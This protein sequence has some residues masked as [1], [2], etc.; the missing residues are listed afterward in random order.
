M[1]PP[2]KG[3]DL[4]DE[5]MEEGEE[6]EESNNDD[7]ASDVEDETK[8][9]LPS[10]EELTAISIDKKGFLDGILGGEEE[11]ANTEDEISDQD[12]VNKKAAEITIEARQGGFAPIQYEASE[13]PDL[14][15]DSV[16]P[17]SEPQDTT[18]KIKSALESGRTGDKGD[19][20]AR[21]LKMSNADFI[22]LSVPGADDNINPEAPA[23]AQQA[24]RN[25]KL[26]PTGQHPEDLPPWLIGPDA[27]EAVKYHLDPTVALHYEI[28]EFARFMAPTKEEEDSRKRLLEVLGE[29]VHGLF[30]NA[31]LEIFGSYA[32]DLYLPSSDI[33]ICIM[34]TPKEGD[35]S[36]LYLLAQSIRNTKGFARRV[37]VI[38]ARVP[39][40]KI[41]SATSKI[42]CDISF[43][44]PNGPNNVPMIKSFLSTYPA[45]RPLILVIKCFLQQRALNEVYTGGIGSYT[46]LMM[47]V[48]HL[49]MSQFNFPSGQSNLGAALQK[50]FRFYGRQLNYV[51]TG[52]TIKDSSGYFRKAEKYPTNNAEA[53]RI[54][55]EDPNDE[56]NELGRNSYGWHRVRKAFEHACTQLCRWN[57]ANPRDP[58][59]PLK[60][61]L[62]TDLSFQTRV[63]EVK[64]YWATQSQQALYAKTQADVARGEKSA[65]G[66][67]RF[68]N[69]NKAKLDYT[70]QSGE[71]RSFSR[72]NDRDARAKRSRQS[73]SPWPRSSRYRNGHVGYDDKRDDRH[74]ERYSDS[75]NV[76]NMGSYPHTM[77][78]AQM[79]PQM[80]QQYQE[81]RQLQEM[82]MQQMQ[83]A[84]GASPAQQYYPNMG[85]DSMMGPPS[86]L[87]RMVQNNIPQSNGSQ[88]TWLAGRPDLRQQEGGRRGNNRNNYDR[89][90]GRGRRNRY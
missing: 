14:F 26:K 31:V 61:I 6:R 73:D 51:V 40:V 2:S 84:M 76:P 63:E 32:T 19:V 20:P 42:Q 75:N 28:L 22:E 9:R 37:N 58:V 88:G 66:L 17:E 10:L 85:R 47:V 27:V 54:S 41:V 60:S 35:I 29:I 81:Q 30:P 25:A 33:D 38:K 13:G 69:R 43:N 11:D 8:Q 4:K 39:L 65:E 64:A 50:F 67:S 45:V 83:Y 82:Q 59:T 18:A 72:Y 71:K 55:I 57:R 78:G 77:A 46:L 36:E 86:G 5:S 24:S 1:A 16:A 70:N 74:N 15:F 53:K 80:Q 89:R 52:L 56:T 44:R 12:D 87:N 21:K 90:N 34:N 48:S 49:R 62:R 68:T 7:E 23:K 3:V 79:T